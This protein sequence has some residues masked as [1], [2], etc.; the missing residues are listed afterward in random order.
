[1]AKFFV[2]SGTLRTII[3]AESAQKAA[4]WAIH[5]V[6]GQVLPL[7]PAV[8]GKPWSSRPAEHG[9]Q[10]HT[11]E[12]IVRVSDHGYDT[13]NIRQW[14]TLQL[15]SQW[16]ELVTTLNRLEKMLHRVAA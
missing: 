1:M 15:V 6:L 5:Q 10:M 12:S 16:N 14:E 8:E 11:L 13:G 9:S 2:Q 4:V 7:D 3:H